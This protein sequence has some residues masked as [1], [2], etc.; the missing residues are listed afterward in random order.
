VD[1]GNPFKRLD[2]SQ[3]VLSQ[4]S[5]RKDEKK[6]KT[7]KNKKTKFSPQFVV[8]TAE[9]SGTEQSAEQSKPKSDQLAQQRTRPPRRTHGGGAE[10]EQDH[11]DREDI[12][13]SIYRLC[14]LR[15]CSRVLLANVGPHPIGM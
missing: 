13:H 10:E 4:H 6:S 15:L 9:I 3:L 8:E 2:K 11:V 12:G 14:C 1:G 7:N 5:P